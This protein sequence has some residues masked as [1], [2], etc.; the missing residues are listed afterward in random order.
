MEN[1]DIQKQQ[2][3]R[4]DHERRRLA[5]SRR[6]KEEEEHKQRFTK[7]DSKRRFREQRIR[8]RNDSGGR[9][10]IR[11]PGNKLPHPSFPRTLDGR[12]GCANSTIRKSARPEDKDQKHHLQDCDPCPEQRNLSSTEGNSVIEQQT[13]TF[14]SSRGNNEDLLWD[15]STRTSDGSSKP[16]QDHHRSNRCNSDDSVGCIH[17]AGIANKEHQSQMGR[18]CP[19]TIYSSRP[20]RLLH[21]KTIY[22]GSGEVLQMPKIRAHNKNMSSNA[23]NV[24]NLQW[25]PQNNCM[26]RE[27]RNR[28]CDNQMQQLQRTARIGLKSMSCKN[29]ESTSDTEVTNSQTSNSKN[30]PGI[31][32]TSTTNIQ[33]NHQ[34]ICT[35]NGGLSSCANSYPRKTNSSKGK[36]QNHQQNT[37][38]EKGR[39]MQASVV[40][41]SNQ[42]P[43]KE[44]CSSTA[45]KSS[46]HASQDSSISA[47]S[48]TSNPGNNR[49]YNPTEPQK[50]R[51]TRYVRANSGH[52]H[53]TTATTKTSSGSTRQ[54]SKDYHQI[55]DN[56]RPKTND[57]TCGAG[58]DQALPEAATQINDSQDVNLSTGMAKALI[59]MD[60]PRELKIVHWNA[61]GANRKRALITSCI[62]NEGIDIML[63]QDTRLKK[64]QDGRVPI[65]VPGCH[66]FYK[67]LDENCHGLLT[68]VRKN[69]PVQLQKTTNPGENTE[70]LTVKIWLQDEALLIHNMYRVK[71][72]I[73]LIK[74]L[75]NPIPAFIG[76]DIN[77][78]HLLWDT[79]SDAAGRKI[80]NQL[81]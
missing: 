60:M 63:I 80:M 66:T 78:H 72:T 48:Q 61:Q 18:L 23:V 28:T 1:G 40:C 25:E 79:K 2:R 32:Q 27:E 6:R 71:N 75:N 14:C 58:L 74:L 56:I 21:S 4:V 44:I 17:Q 81:E 7:E 30:N 36:Q 46:G 51:S 64:R 34:G 20:S 11:V 77:A 59:G 24:R 33:S 52:A 73:D 67:P 19:S 8:R 15:C 69:I 41:R 9:G 13:R 57:T 76:C 62:I 26:S 29:P 12:S 65:R 68:I 53:N 5:E 3:E 49:E 31:Q 70:I 38:S 43:V 16:S 50:A 22:S 35:N 45:Q 10:Y 47:A 54:R 37:N 55:N 39:R 42:A